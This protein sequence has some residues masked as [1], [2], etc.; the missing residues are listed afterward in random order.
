MK[1]IEPKVELWSEEGVT[2]EQH[3]A[4]C[5][6]VCY[7]HEGE[8]KDPKMLVQALIKSGHCYTEDSEVL[9]EKGWL[10]W[11]DYKGEKVAVVNSDLS[12]K[13]F[14]KPIA[15]INHPYTG[16]FYSY[17]SLGIEVTDG[18]RMFGCFRSNSI[19]FQKDNRYVLFECN[20]P[21]ATSSKPSG[22]ET[23]GERTFKVP[24]C[25]KC[26]STTLAYFELIGF[27]IGDGCASGYE[28]IKDTLY[29]HL[30]KERKIEYLKGL[31]KRLNYVFEVLPNNKY[32]VRR[33]GIGREFVSKYW[34]NME[35]YLPFDP[36][37]T[38]NQIYSVL[39]GLINSDG[40]RC[41][42]KN[43]NTI[44]FC[45]TSKPIIDWIMAFA[46]L[47]GYAVSGLKERKSDNPKH[48]TS[49][50]LNLLVY[51]YKIVNEWGNSKTRVQITS[52]HV[53]NVYCVTV[54]TGLLLVRGVTGVSVICGNCSML[55]HASHYLRYDNGAPNDTA[56]MMEVCSYNQAYHQDGNIF[57][58]VN[59]QE[60]RFSEDFNYGYAQ[61]EYTPREFLAL[62]KDNPELFAIV[63]LTFCL[64]TQ[65]ST[66]RELNRVSPNNIAERSTRYCSSKDGLEI[67][68]PWWWNDNKFHG[69]TLA[70]ESY[71]DD[72]FF[73]WYDAYNQ[74]KTL[75]KKG[76]K[77]EDA[78]GVLPLD[79]ATKVVYTYSV[80]EWKH[81]I[82][83]RYY[84]KTGK[85]H[86]NAKLIIGMVRD[87]INE[88][89]EKHGVDYKL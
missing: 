33:K 47:G 68:K 81:I 74:Y 25:C 40:S 28:K 72:A 16:S 9:T 70:G 53:D 61:K 62:C 5:A 51:R 13:G 14:E 39:L 2:P 89:A 43:T 26:P 41:E 6:R 35:K 78:R 84:G 69:L 11:R 36:N 27:W 85:P 50:V 66:S 23:F 73:A 52:K 37:V 57:L 32:R 10:K 54:S 17:P 82:D 1:L 64:T 19:P 60:Y 44:V 76:M 58:S 30:K 8:G 42:P 48:K 38:D 21:Y 63:R 34:R 46:P 71:E 22:V 86:P 29:F 56:G 12:F 18:H 77:P 31:C 49:Y 24:M 4:R 75:L 83:L 20:T 87:K 67:C 79:T 3:I 88:F 59:D 80:A 55:R 65:I 7:G 15:I 45:N